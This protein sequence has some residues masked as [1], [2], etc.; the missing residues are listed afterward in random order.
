MSGV[1]VH[2]I[3][4]DNRCLLRTDNLRIAC[5]SVKE[6]IAVALQINDAIM[7][8]LRTNGEKI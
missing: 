3:S 4:R 7:A 1:V 6:L 2:P 5:M 8:A